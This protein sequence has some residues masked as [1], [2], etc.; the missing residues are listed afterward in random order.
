MKEYKANG[1]LST[2]AGGNQ[3]GIDV[4]IAAERSSLDD[5]LMLIFFFALYPLARKKGDILY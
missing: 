5:I 1:C 3:S 4:M 2:F